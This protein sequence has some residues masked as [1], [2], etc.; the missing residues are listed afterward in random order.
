MLG[1]LGLLGLAA[2]FD[3]HPVRGAPCATEAECPI[4]QACVASVCGGL[5]SITVDAG[6]DAPPGVDASPIADRDGDGVADA[7]DNCPDIANPDQGNEDG[8]ALGDACDPCPIDVNNADPDGDGVGGSCDPHPTT[9]G[10][11]IVAFEGFHRGIPAAWQIVGTAATSGDDAVVTTV[12]GNHTAVVPPVA[13]IANGTV[14]ASVV[15]D[16]TVGTADAAMTI[17][18]P[19]DP[20]QDQGIF[21]ELYAPNAGSANGHYV[22]LWDSPA[23]NER[24]KRNFAWTAATAYRMVLTRTGKDYLCSATPAGGQAQTANGS[25]SSTT[26]Q[27]KPT[28]AA[29]GANAHVAWML[30]VSS[31]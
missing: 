10:D 2:C 1:L 17:G 25:T 14:M 12:A 8:D 24:A 5:A 27:S 7:T 23:Q 13:S 3:P 26:T 6:L 28:L 21:C 4:G 18:L 31:P 9:P 16:A 19:Y 22:A 20:A 30:V 29:Y 15:V 11:K